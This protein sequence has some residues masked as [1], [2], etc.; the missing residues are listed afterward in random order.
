MTDPER[1]VDYAIGPLEAGDTFTLRGGDIQGEMVFRR[2]RETQPPPRPVAGLGRA[3][4]EAAGTPLPTERQPPA[5]KT[6]KPTRAPKFRVTYT[7]ADTVRLVATSDPAHVTF[8]GERGVVLTTDG[9]ATWERVLG[10]EEWVGVLAPGRFLDRY[11]FFTDPTLPDTDFTQPSNV[12]A[13]LNQAFQ[14]ERQ[15]YMFF[16]MW[17][18]VYDRRNS[19]LTYSGAGHPPE[20]TSLCLARVM[21]T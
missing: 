19:T 13:S 11:V 3:K 17:Y 20:T 12:L 6:V 10:D 14:M 4:K 21:A 8:R 15:N 7:Y 5:P 1:G 16:T 2:K 9:G 18:G